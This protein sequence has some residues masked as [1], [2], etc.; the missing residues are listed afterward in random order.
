MNKTEEILHY[1][2]DAV[3]QGHIKKG[4]RL[5]GCRELSKQ[6]GMNKLTINKAYKKLE[7]M[8]IVYCIPRGGYYLIDTGEEKASE[9]KTYQLHTVS[10]DPNLI[11]YQAFSHAMNQAVEDQKKNLFQYDSPLGLASL[12]DIL[13]SRFEEDGIY[14]QSSRILISNG[15]QQGIYL[16]LKLLF[17]EAQQGQLLLEEP[18]Y[19]AALS[20]A[21]SLNIDCISIPREE[22]GINL[23]RL[24]E[25][26][27]KHLIKAFYII[28]R[29]H[30]PT[31]FSLKENDKKKIVELCSKYRVFLIEDDYLAELCPDKHSMP[32]HYYDIEK[33]H[34]YIRSFSKTFLP[35]LRLGAVVLPEEYVD[36]AMRSKYLFDICTSSLIQGALEVFMKSGMYDSHI[37]R[38]NACYKQKLWKVQSM[39]SGYCS[40]LIDLYIPKQGLFLW[41]RLPKEIQL[42]RIL[43]RLNSYHIQLGDPTLFYR[44][45][46][47]QTLRISICGIPEEELCILLT[48]FD[49]INQELNSCL[50]K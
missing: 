33:R 36:A 39:L 11:P 45:S 2:Q 16:V 38:V 50:G 15:A 32:L 7:D 46:S 47:E 34:F 25:L 21:K 22:A 42:D 8:H 13:R 40:P 23:T 49:I 18:T 35:G 10:P 4:Q 6:L 3:K 30:N 14:T 19:S 20:I 5:P 9:P 41:V 28:P 31:G 26:F 12:R 17:S 27:Q 24:E 43:E 1:I 29:F 44:T 48:V 37:K